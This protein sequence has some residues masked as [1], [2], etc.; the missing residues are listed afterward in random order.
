MPRTA[1]FPIVIFFCGDP[2]GNFSHIIDAVE[3]H[4][5]N[6][7]VLL[8]DMQA[9]TPLDLELAPIL[10]VTEVWFIPGNHDTASDADYDNV[11]GTAL[12][13][14]N[15]HC[16]VAEIGGLRIAG[17]GGV[18]RSQVWAPPAPW[19]YETSTE[20][21]AR[22]GKGNRWRGGLPRRHRSSIFPGDLANL[23]SQRADILV[24]HE[25]PSCHPHG[26]QVI[27]EIARKMGVRQTFHG[28]HH[29]CLD[30]SEHFDRL[31]FAAYGVGFCGITDE[32]GAVIRQGDLD[33]VRPRHDFSK[34]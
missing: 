33:D 16:R 7:V 17:L 8:G 15:L 25:A 12:A 4:H 9:Q 21:T 6:A 2:H 29:D 10:D 3:E 18:F 14:R 19:E 13:G 32:T 1:R 26:F 24:T 20:F 11:F 27:D 5:P 30:Y 23:A 28:H 22:C 31:G 34:Q